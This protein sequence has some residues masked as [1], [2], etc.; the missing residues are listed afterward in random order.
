MSPGNSSCGPKIKE[1]WEQEKFHKAKFEEL[2]NKYRVRPSVLT[3]LWNV[4]G[5]CL[6]AGKIQSVLLYSMDFEWDYVFIY[7]LLN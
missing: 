1:M 4:A 7:R 5:F 3:P 2:I 6:G